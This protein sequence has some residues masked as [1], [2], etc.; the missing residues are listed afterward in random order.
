MQK[1]NTFLMQLACFLTGYRYDLVEMSSEVTRKNVKKYFGGILVISAIWAYIG[2]HFSK[3]YLKLSDEKAFIGSLVA[4][5]LVIQVERQI[6]LANK[7]SWVKWFRIFLGV[8]MA[9]IGSILIDQ[10][11]Y[12]D[13][14]E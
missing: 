2:F 13:D 14:I 7:S 12:Q 1:F 5:F 4:V 11:I 10:K 9:F 6:L 8:V 3:T